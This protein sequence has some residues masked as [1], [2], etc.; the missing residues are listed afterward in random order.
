MGSNRFAGE[1]LSVKLESQLKKDYK[2]LRYLEARAREA[3]NG[4][5]PDENVRKLR[6]SYGYKYTLSCIYRALKVLESL[7]NSRSSSTQ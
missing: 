5:T 4:F 2:E 3:M 7:K 6:N 1:P